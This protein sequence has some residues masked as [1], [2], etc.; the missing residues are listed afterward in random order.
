LSDHAVDI[1][2]VSNVREITAVAGIGLLF[3]LSI[4]TNLILD[5]NECGRTVVY[6]LARL[7][8][9]VAISPVFSG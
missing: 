9:K 7:L 5:S 8:L 1:S 6:N 2:S 4:E 3:K